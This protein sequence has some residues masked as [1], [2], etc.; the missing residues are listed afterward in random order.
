MRLAW[1]SLATI[2]AE[3]SE[4]LILPYKWILATWFGSAIPHAGICENSSPEEWKYYR[5]QIDPGNSSE[6]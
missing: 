6:F 5:G 2:A 1:E 4:T 3:E